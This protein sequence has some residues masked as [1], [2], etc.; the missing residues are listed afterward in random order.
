MLSPVIRRMAIRTLVAA[1]VALL[2]SAANIFVLTMLRGRELGWICLGSCSADVVINAIALF[3]VTR[4]S[5][6]PSPDSLDEHAEQVAKQ[7]VDA[8]M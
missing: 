6:H 7:A 1:T 3:W 4:P 8:A 5:A 2:T